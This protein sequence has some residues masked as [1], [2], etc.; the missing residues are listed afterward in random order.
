[1]A[2]VLLESESPVGPTICHLPIDHGR[3]GAP[4]SSLSLLLT[5]TTLHSTMTDRSKPAALSP[6]YAIGILLSVPA[7]LLLA[8]RFSDAWPIPKFLAVAMVPAV[9]VCLAAWIETRRRNR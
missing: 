1:M 3:R 8:M 9:I 2:I 7:G 4:F 5:F 6:G